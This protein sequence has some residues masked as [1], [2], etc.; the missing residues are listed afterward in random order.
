MRFRGGGVGHVVPTVLTEPEPDL[1]D[2]VLY[3]DWDTDLSEDVHKK[4]EPGSSSED[5][6]AEDDEDA[7]EDAEEAEDEDRDEDEDEESEVATPGEEDEDEDTL[8]DL[9][10]DVLG[11][12][13]L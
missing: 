8:V 7:E 12:G 3:P 9:M 2:D 10:N 4:D 13:A 1:D 5:G 6:E 11:Y